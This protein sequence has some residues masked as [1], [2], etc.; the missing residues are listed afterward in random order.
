MSQPNPMSLKINLNL[1]E[2]F[3]PQPATPQP[4]GSAKRKSCDGGCDDCPCKGEA[5]GAPEHG[6]HTHKGG[7]DEA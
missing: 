2:V 6:P 5:H 4:A 1:L 7:H 3:K